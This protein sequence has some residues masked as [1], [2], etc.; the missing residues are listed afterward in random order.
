MFTKHTVFKISVEVS[1]VGGFC[2]DATVVIRCWYRLDHEIVLHPCL[3]ST[4]DVFGHV[5]ACAGLKRF[6]KL[7]RDEMKRPCARGYCS[8][9]WPNSG[10]AVD[11]IEGNSLSENLDSLLFPEGGFGSPSHTMAEGSASRAAA[12]T[13]ALPAGVTPDRFHNCGS[14][15]IAK[16]TASVRSGRSPTMEVI[17]KRQ[18]ALI[19]SQTASNGHKSIVLT[20]IRASL[21]P[22]LSQ[23]NFVSHS[24]F[25]FTRFFSFFSFFFSFF[26]LPFSPFFFP[27]F[28]HFSLFPLFLL[29]FFSPFFIFLPFFPFLFSLSHFFF[30]FFFSFF[31]SFFF[32]FSIFSYFFSCFSFFLFSFSF[33]HFFH[34]CFH[35]FSFFIMFSP[36]SFFTFFTFFSPFFFC[37]HFFFSFLSF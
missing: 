14:F 10:V 13:T 36:F 20:G 4:S 23:Q 19:R 24:S 26:F 18:E 27:F 21:I 7:K 17:E 30:F 5:V 2:Q 6:R 25:S 12:V 1:A 34:H 16:K 33:C 37:F 22:A 8:A 28:S 29:F 3:G 15:W 32:F 11:Q 31:F 9:N 35:C